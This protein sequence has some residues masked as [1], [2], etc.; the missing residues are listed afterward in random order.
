MSAD[1]PLNDRPLNRLTAE[2][3]C[4]DIQYGIVSKST[5]S[6]PPAPAPG[7]TAQAQS[8]AN[9]DTAA[10]QAALDYVNQNTPYG[11]TTYAQTGTYNTPGGETVPTYT[12]DTTL[13]PLGQAIYTGQQ[14]VTNTLLPTAQTLATNAGASATTPLNF[15]TADSATLNAAPQQLDANSA[16]AVFQQEEQFLQPQQA[17]QS[18][19]LQDQL[20]RQGISV[21]NDA[22]SNAETQLGTQ[23]N[24]ATQSAIDTAIGQGTQDAATNFNM[25]LA[26]QQQNIAQQQTGQTNQLSLLQSLFGASPASQ[27]QPITSPTAVPIS[28]TNVLGAQALSTNTA[29]QNYQAQLAQ[30][31]SMFGGL[32]G[33]AGSLGSAYIL[34]DAR[35]KEGIEQIGTLFDGQPV[36]RFRYKGSSVW[37]IGLM[38]QDVE[39]IA[40]EAVQ[41]I[42]GT[43]Y[44]DYFLATE[45]ARKAKELEGVF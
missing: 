9:V 26:G 20:S 40:P 27:S 39:Q 11:S 31:N 44:V 7:P 10:A 34:S 14:N 37:H 25:A 41:E 43:K 18:K 1:K 21:G 32:A 19:D 15:N 38:A 16:N 6:P 28:P 30:S 17:Q 24:Q 2:E 23:Q 42:G 45:S 22:Y 8:A 3:W 4:C 12:Q 29:E 36:Y 13:S 35:R 33:L 5:P